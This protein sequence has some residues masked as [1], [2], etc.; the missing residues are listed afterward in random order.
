MDFI[1]S[2]ID[3]INTALW[4]YALLFLL[5]G[6]GIYFTIRLKFIQVR[7]FTEGFRRL[8][9]G[10]KL[11]G[12]K[13][14]ADGMSSFQALTT[15]IAAQVGT[16]NIAGAATAI[17][18]GGPGAIFWMW[19]SAFFG[20]ATIFAEAVLAQKYKTTVEG[21]VTGGPIYY[22]RAAFQGKLGKFLAVFFSIAVILALGFMGNMVQSNSIG[23]AMESAF[24]VPAVAAGVVGSDNCRLYFSR[25]CKTHCLG[26][27]KNSSVYGAVLHCGL[28]DHFVHELCCCRGGIPSDLCYGFCAAVRRGRSDGYYRAKGYA[29]W[30]S[31]R[32][33]FK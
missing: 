9:G 31:A 13:A 11:N 29:F 6:T 22:I 30:S 16:G 28:R 5:C 7:K 19:V 21:E 20:M 32:F 14:G 17:V 18:S 26:N 23:V 27:R 33:V 24:G 15:A 10:L 3:A 2:V 25:W 1:L 12:K 8:F 4:D